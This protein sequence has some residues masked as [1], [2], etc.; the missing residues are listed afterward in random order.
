V[1]AT[2]GGTAAASVTVRDAAD[3]D[4]AAVQAIYAHHVVHGLGSFEEAPP[5][6]A[7][8]AARR[9]AVMD[10]GLPYLVAEEGGAIRGYAYAGPFRPRPAYRYALENSVYVAPDAMGRGIGR[11]LLQILVERCAALGYRQM[12]AVIGH[13]GNDGSIGLHAALGFRR[14]AHLP[15]VGFKFG[16]WVD[17]VIMQRAL[18][19]GD[20]TFPG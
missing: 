19:Q 20:D 7:E 9:R 18:G 14:V 4:M 16:R 17:L 2:A 3:A 5:D 10:K 12:I 6:L 13:A 15:S 8:M 1:T 11:L